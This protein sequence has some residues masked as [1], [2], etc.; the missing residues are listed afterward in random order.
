MNKKIVIG[1]VKSAYGLKG[2]FRI[3]TYTE[4]P[5]NIFKYD[6]VDF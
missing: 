5:S 3:Q 1:Q 6:E 2:Q 4:E